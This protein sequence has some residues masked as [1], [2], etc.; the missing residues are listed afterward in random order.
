VLES[1]EDA[2]KGGS[3][4]AR[5]ATFVLG[6]DKQDRQYRAIL[7]FPTY[8]LPDNAV[9]TRVLLMIKKEGVAGQ[10]PP[11]RTRTSWWTSLGVRLRPVPQRFA[12]QIFKAHPAWTQ[13]A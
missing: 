6:D 8:Y 13:L 7:D 3:L 5:T 11:P 2:N 12:N 9:I 10:D 4:N 1:G